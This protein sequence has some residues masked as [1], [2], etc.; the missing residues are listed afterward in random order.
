MGKY[1]LLWEMD[2]TRIPI[3]PKERGTGWKA[4]MDMVK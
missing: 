4:L 1:L 3:D 2:Q